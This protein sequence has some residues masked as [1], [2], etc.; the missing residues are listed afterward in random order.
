MELHG[1]AAAL[2]NPHALELELG[3]VAM[4]LA[5]ELSQLP[6]LLKLKLFHEGELSA[7]GSSSLV[8]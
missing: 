3:D 4:L 5:H 2:R 6:L 1:L 8:P 7:G